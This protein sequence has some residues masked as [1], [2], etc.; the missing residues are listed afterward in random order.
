MITSIYLTGAAGPIIDKNSRYLMVTRPVPDVDTK[1]F[2][3]DR[4]RIVVKNPPGT[5]SQIMKVGE[6]TLV[7]ISG[8]LEADDAANE[9]LR[10]HGLPESS[11]VVIAELTE[12]Y[13]LES[14]MGGYEET[15]LKKTGKK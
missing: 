11:F 10:K 5:D 2:K 13:T 8:R 6:G 14:N 3:T 12:V 9:V 1:N 4:F 15:F 7:I